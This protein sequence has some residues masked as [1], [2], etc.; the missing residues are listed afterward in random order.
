MFLTVC[1]ES[2]EEEGDS[3]FVA[4]LR[5]SV[6]C[7]HSLSLSLIALIIVT[8][9]VQARWCKCI[10]PSSSHPSHPPSAILEGVT[11]CLMI[12]HSQLSLSDLSVQLCGGSTEIHIC[13][14][15]SF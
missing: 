8:K 4:L 7:C 6:D 1:V 15:F 9:Y 10:I 3:A 2:C 5:L 11:F 14:A 12:I 13:T